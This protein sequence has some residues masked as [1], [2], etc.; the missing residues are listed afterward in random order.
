MANP[1]TRLRQTLP[2]DARQVGTVQ[3]VNGDGTSDVLMVGGGVIRAV[4]SDFSAGQPV[5]VQGG[6]ILSA[7]PTL[8]IQLVEV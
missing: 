2:Q 8:N 6:Q 1:W 5:F 7:A 4:G 3:T